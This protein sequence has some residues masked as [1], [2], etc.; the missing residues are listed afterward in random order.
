MKYDLKAMSFDPKSN[1]ISKAFIWQHT[2][3]GY[4][5]WLKQCLDELPPEGQ[6]KWDA[7]KQQWNEENGVEHEIGTLEEL[8]VKPGDVVSPCP[9]GVLQYTIGIEGGDYIDIKDGE[10]LSDTHIF[11]LISRTEPQRYVVETPTYTIICNRTE[12]ETRAASGVATVYK[13]G[14]KV[15]VTVKVEFE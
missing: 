14:D 11:R 6:A 5:Y 9:K 3:E 1:H 8:D 12:A 2:P 4:G 13:L 15:N 7:M 10:R